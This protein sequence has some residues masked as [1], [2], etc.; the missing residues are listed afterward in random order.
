MASILKTNLQQNPSPPHSVTVQG[1]YEPFDLQVARNQIMGHNT[2]FISGFN[3]TVGTTYETVWSE[4]TVYVYPTTA[5]I[6][7]ISSSDANDTAAGTGARTVTIYGLDANYNQIN[8]TV[9]LSGQTAV[10]TTN[11]YLRVFHLMV[12]T[13]GS[14]GA[15]AGSIYAGVGTV[16]TGKPATVYG[17]YTADGGATA[18]IYTVPAGYTGYIFDFLTSTGCTTANAYTNIGLYNRPLGGVLDN[19]IQGRCGNG[20]AF[21]IPLNY[22]LVFDEKTDIEVRASATSTSNV[23]ANF[24]IVIIK[25]DGQTA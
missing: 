24:N 15:A 18:C 17:V 19:T 11:S 7:K 5:T 13:A 10:N 16:T 25:N 9:S 1:A 21:T 22:P 12:N 20:G 8:E 2:V 6:I 14:G 3:A 4:S 23:T